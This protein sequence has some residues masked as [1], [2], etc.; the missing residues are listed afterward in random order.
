[1][2]TRILIVLMLAMGVWNSYGQIRNSGANYLEL[3]AGK[4]LLFSD[5]GLSWRAGESVLGLS[6]AIGSSRG[7]YH[8][9]TAKYRKEYVSSQLVGSSE[10]YDNYQFGYSYEKTLHIGKKHLSY[11]GLVYGLGLGIENHIPITEQTSTVAYP[12]ATLGLR[13]EK[14]LGPNVGILIG[15][16]ADA[17]TSVISQKGKSN[18]FLGVKFKL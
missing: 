5:N 18:L 17:T 12:Y 6:Y 11:W 8:R 16:D 3:W 14:F 2:K 1:M 13:Y 4:P 15:L 9:L 7:N 10:H